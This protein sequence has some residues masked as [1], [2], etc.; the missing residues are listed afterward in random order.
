MTGGGRDLEGLAGSRRKKGGTLNAMSVDVEDYFQVEAFS[1]RIS[2]GSW[3]GIPRRV[4]NNIVRILELFAASN[5][6][7]TFF[8][9]GWI[10]ERHPGMMREIA[11]RG[12]EIA[13]HGY[14]HTRVD[15]LG[16]SRFRADIR[17]SKRIL[18]D[19]VGRPVLGYRAPTFSLEVGT[20]W[21]YDILEGEG[22]RYSSSVYPIRHDLHGNSA[23]PRAPFR[24]ANRAFWE[25]PLTTRRL[26]GQN[27]PSAGGGY[28]RLFPYALSR[29]NLAAVNRREARAS[30]FYFHPWEI[31]AEQPRV[32]SIPFRTR[33]RHYT[34]LNV[35]P[36]RIERL[37]RE[38]RWG[39]IDEVFADR[40]V[41][42]VERPSHG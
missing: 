19:I 36:A 37:L 26:F 27:I 25:L 7:A 21:A 30:I 10:A 13:S 16:P 15:H 31:D 8:A 28:F 38:F 6:C 3:E 42:P 5:V 24:P 11:A 34:N 17:R 22:Y 12:H 33:L 4:E 41:A 18:E 35:M 39:R 2:R 29:W 20:N 14:D 1:G 23:A 40:L 9:L 32:R